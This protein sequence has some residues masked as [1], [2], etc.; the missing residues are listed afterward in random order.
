[1]NKD[2]RNYYIW[3]EKSFTERIEKEEISRD[4]YILE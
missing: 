4:K 1:M 2:Y 3:N